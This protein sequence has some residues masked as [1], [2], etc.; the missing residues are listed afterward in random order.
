[1]H[2]DVTIKLF[3]VRMKKGSSHLAKPILRI[4][5]YFFDRL[6]KTFYQVLEHRK[7]ASQ[8][9]QNGWFAAFLFLHLVHLKR[10]TD[11]FLEHQPVA[12][13][14]DIVFPAIATVGSRLTKLGDLLSGLLYDLELGAGVGA[15]EADFAMVTGK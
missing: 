15:E 8:P 14:Q 2:T 12:L 4:N 13:L 7:A 10:R 1:M 3:F 11:L 6:R 9:P 5:T